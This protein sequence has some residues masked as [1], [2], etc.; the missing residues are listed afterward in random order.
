[1]TTRVILLLGGRRAAAGS[2]SAARRR[3]RAGSRARVR[4]GQRP[5][6]DRQPEFPP[7]TIRQYKP[8]S[9]LVVPQ[10]PVPRAK[11]PVIDI[12]SH[13]PT[14]M[15]PRSSRTGRVDGSAEPAPARQRER[16]ESGE[17]LVRSVAAI[18]DSPHRDR[19]VHV[20]GHRLPGTSPPAS[21]RAAARQLEADVKAGAVGVG[22]I[23]KGFGLTHRKADGTRLRSTTPNST[24]CG[25]RPR[26][27]RFRCSSTGR[28]GGVLRTD[29]LHQRAVA[30]AGAVSGPPLPAA[31]FPV[32]R[33]ADGGTRPAV[34]A[35]SEDDVHRGAPRLARQRPGADGKLF[36]EMPNVYSEMGAV[37]YELGRQPRA[38]HDF[39]VKY[40]DR[41]LFGKDTYQPDE[42][43]YFWRV[44]ETRTSTSTTTAITTRSGSCTAWRCPIRCCGSS[45]TRTR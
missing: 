6:A 37:L 34:H 10:H 40:Q 16:C 38:A 35:P 21:A 15:P 17:S 11:F 24:R 30:G 29:G 19:M 25:R 20:R 36:D 27:S 4:S 18:R 23:D 5:G 44:F 26:V 22:E 8:R 12:H 42:Y 28:A 9:T 2:L 33:G 1:M 32:V 14:P 41:L 31:Q 39:F 3:R 7:P 13:Q 43:P 45:T